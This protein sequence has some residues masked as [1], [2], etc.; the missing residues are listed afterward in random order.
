M[1]DVRLPS[2][3]DENACPLVHD[4]MQ[5]HITFR[6]RYLEDSYSKTLRKV[7]TCTPINTVSCNRRLES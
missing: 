2:S 4:A 7:G 6:K 1:R 3:A 5:I